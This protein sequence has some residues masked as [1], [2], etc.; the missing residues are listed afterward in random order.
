MTVRDLD[1]PLGNLVNEIAVMGNGKHR[2]PEILDIPFQPFHASEV[3]VVRR[4]VQKQDVRLFQ[5]KTGEVRPGL[6]A[7]GQ[8]VKFLGA[9]LCRD[10][11][12]VADLVHIHV[13]FIAAPGLEAVGQAVVFPQLLRRRALRH[14]RFQPLHSGFHLHEAGVGG[15]QHILHGVARRELGDLGN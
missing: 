6:F 5:Q 14:I 8:A 2:S 13:H 11:Q 7:A 9:L 15:V 4:L 12:T 3:Q 1:H 10:A